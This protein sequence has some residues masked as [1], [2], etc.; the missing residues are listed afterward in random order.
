MAKPVLEVRSA[1]HR[2]RD[3]AR[4]ARHLIARSEGVGCLLALL[5]LNACKRSPDVD[6]IPPLPSPSLPSAV[7]PSPEAAPS[8]S[9]PV[10]ID[11]ERLRPGDIVFQTSRSAQSRAV[12]LATRSP[13]SHMGVVLP[14]GGALA[15]YEAVGP[16]K[17]TP[18]AE[19]VA[20]GENGRVLV[21]RL[22]EPRALASDQVE[23]LV[24]SAE[25]FLGKPYDGA[26]AWSDDRLYCSEVVWKIFRRA[27]GVELGALT[28]LGD[29]DLANP[30][31]QAK[32]RERYGGSIPTEEP[33]IS[34][35]AMAASP[36][37]ETVATP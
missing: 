1:I 12:Q 25:K 4:R 31:V 15:V 19:W 24:R 3:R 17:Y 28:R 11:L 18:V 10:A 35:A 30:E 22:R 36:L 13:L 20:R 16:V 27:L 21:K 2:P 37:L 6:A 33:V 7:A 34:P 29:F 5:F 8:S 23:L 26:F 14:H 9:A 32:L